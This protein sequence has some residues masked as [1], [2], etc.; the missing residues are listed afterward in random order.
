M[1]PGGGRQSPCWNRSD[2]VLKALRSHGLG[3]VA[4]HHHMRG[5]NDWT[6]FYTNYCTR[7]AVVGFTLKR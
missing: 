1:M 7:F 2:P 5:T 4:I 6:P 3:R